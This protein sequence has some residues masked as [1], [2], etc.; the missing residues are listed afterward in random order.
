MALLWAVGLC[1]LCAVL[2]ATLILLPLAAILFFC[3]MFGV[4]LWVIYRI[5]RGWL[6]LKDGLQP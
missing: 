4:G 6:N 5:A 2:A 1:L 3:G